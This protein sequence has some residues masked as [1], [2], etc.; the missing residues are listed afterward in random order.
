MMKAASGSMRCG[1]RGL[2]DRRC[3]RQNLVS[4]AGTWQCRSWFLCEIQDQK[5][6][7]KHS[8]QQRWQ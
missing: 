6:C 3:R 8:D 7:C 2:S 1:L 4:R 5:E